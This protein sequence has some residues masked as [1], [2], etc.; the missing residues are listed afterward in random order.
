MGRGRGSSR[1][2]PLPGNWPQIRADR[3]AIDGYRCTHTRSDTGLRCTARATDA[4]HI[5]NPSDHRIE[6]LRSKCG[7]HHRQKTSR[8]AGH[9]SAQAARTRAAAAQPVHPGLLTPD[10][11]AER[12]E[13]CPF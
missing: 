7:W 13:P 4:D 10:E 11:I 1:T 6:M 9:A 2:V 8:D 5:G 3:L 12:D